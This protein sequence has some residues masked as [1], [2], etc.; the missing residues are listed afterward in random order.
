MLL[1]DRFMHDQAAAFARR[2]M[3]EAGSDRRAQ[4]RGAYA[5][6]FGRAPSDS[7]LT[8]ALV[9]LHR[10]EQAFCNLSS[11]NTFHLDV[12]NAL[13]TQY[14]EQLA[15]SQ[16]L[17]GPAE[18]WNYYRG[19]WAPPYEGIRVVNRDQAPFALWSGATFRDG[20]I[21]T[22]VLFSKSAESAS[23]LFRARAEGEIARGYELVLNPRSREVV[24]HKHTDKLQTV[25]HAEAELPVGSLFH[26]KIAATG[27]RISLWLRKESRPLIDIQENDA[28][29]ESGEIGVRAWGGSVSFEN[30]RVAASTGQEARTVP[31]EDRDGAHGAL[32]SFCLLVLNLNELIYID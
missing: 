25:A 5:L 12:P 10:N 28:T 11:R 16:F 15:P 14:F 20:V 32:E 2:I 7:E 23:L 29:T 3:F 19:A 8:T 31:G 24:L 17:N 13:S 27:S 18:G 9:F 4:V 21:E 30:L 22:D 6:A 1:N 26:L